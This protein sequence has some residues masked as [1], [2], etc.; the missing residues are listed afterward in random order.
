MPTPCKPFTLGR[1]KAVASQFAQVLGLALVLSA[2]ADIFR[3]YGRGAMSEYFGS[4]CCTIKSMS[5]L[6]CR[7]CDYR[8]SLD[9]F[10]QPLG[11]LRL[12]S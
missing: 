4:L 3:G 10:R 8:H 12:R 5:Y 11:H 6:Q 7:R 9:S 1:R 2:L